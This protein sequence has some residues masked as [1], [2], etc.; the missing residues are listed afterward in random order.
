MRKICAVRA[1]L[2]A[3]YRRAVE[4]ATYIMRDGV[5]HVQQRSAAFDD[6]VA[7][8]WAS[9]DSMGELVVSFSLS[10]PV[11]LRLSSL[12]LSGVGLTVGVG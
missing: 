1:A 6:W 3:D 11:R 9:L 4:G 7:A 2:A 12:D 8:G 10:D 5:E